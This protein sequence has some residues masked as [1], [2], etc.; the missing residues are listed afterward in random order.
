MRGLLLDTDVRWNV[1]GMSVDARTDV[2]RGEVAVPATDVGQD[3]GWGLPPRRM[4]RSR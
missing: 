1:I 4:H 3:F 2:E